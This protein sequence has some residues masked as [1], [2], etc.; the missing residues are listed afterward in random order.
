MESFLGKEEGHRRK[1]FLV[2]AF[3]LMVC[4]FVFHRRPDILA[5]SKAYKLGQDVAEMERRALL[6]IF[7]SQREGEDG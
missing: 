2:S 7:Q 4:L 3:L 6:H 5:A 1:V